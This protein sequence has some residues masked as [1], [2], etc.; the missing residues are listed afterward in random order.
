MNSFENPAS[1]N[2]NIPSGEG[3]PNVSEQY[4]EEVLTD[5]NGEGEENPEDVF[6]GEN[7]EETKERTPEENF[8]D[9]EEELGELN[10]VLSGKLQ[11]KERK[12]LEKNK[13]DLEEELQKETDY[14]VEREKEN[15]EQDLKENIGEDLLE[16]IKELEREGRLESLVQELSEDKPSETNTEGPLKEIAKKEPKTALEIIGKYLNNGSK[17]LL[18]SIK[19]G[20]DLVTALLEK[21]LKEE[22]EKKG[23]MPDAPDSEQPSSEETEEKRD[24]FQEIAEQR[25]SEQIEGE[26]EF[27]RKQREEEENIQGAGS[28]EIPA[29]LTG[30]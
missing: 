18:D 5:E 25:V 20:Y 13:I 22:E 12:E 24:I 27:R 2:V 21:I 7:Y 16:E 17:D 8:V 23:A 4:P 6:N 1:Q 28:S 9:M 10:E 15:I 29:S 26:R 19:F 3:Q 14:L 11:E 30:G